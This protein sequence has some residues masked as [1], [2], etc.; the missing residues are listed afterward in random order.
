MSVVASDELI[1]NINIVLQD[2]HGS[3]KII[4]AIED[5]KP[6]E[7]WSGD[8]NPN[9]NAYRVILIDYRDVQQNK[10]AQSLFL[11]AMCCSWYYN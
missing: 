1:S 7:A 5:M 6:F 10:L 9:N 4:S 3:A 8:F 11:K 2:I